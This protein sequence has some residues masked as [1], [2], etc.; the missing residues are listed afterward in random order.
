MIGWK[1]AARIGL[2]VVSFVCYATAVVAVDGS[3]E[4]LFTVEM[5]D[6]Y[7]KQKGSSLSDDDLKRV[8]AQATIV[9]LDLTGCSQISDRGIGSLAGLSELR[10]LRL[11]GCYRITVDGLRSLT[12][13]KNL[14]TLDLSQS[15]LDLKEVYK[16]LQEVPHLRHLEIRDVRGLVT[17]GLEGLP[18]LEYLDLS[19]THGGISDENLKSLA[20]L[21]ELTYLN[22]NGSRNWGANKTLT[23]Q[24]LSHLA[25]LNQLEFLGLFGHFN[26][27]AE[28]YTKLLGGMPKL[29]KL[30][31]GFNWPLHGEALYLPESLEDLNLMESFQ[32]HDAAVLNNMTVC[33]D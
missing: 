11:D 23:D 6:N 1:S 21:K 14:S 19:T 18:R 29:K 22:L 15:R 9:E 16:V 4:S 31:M 28:G 27:T 24:G 26:L 17:K 8:S 12:A 20:S 10:V 3:T 25:G 33:S 2:L 30:E 7:V 32:L 13:L 5:V